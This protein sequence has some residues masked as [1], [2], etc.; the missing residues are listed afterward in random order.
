M[1]KIGEAHRLSNFGIFDLIVNEQTYFC[2][3]KKLTGEEGDGWVR[4]GNKR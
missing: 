3:F 4:N 1:L 2:S